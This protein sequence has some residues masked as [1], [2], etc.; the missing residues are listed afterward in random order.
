MAKENKKNVLS[1]LV[2]IFLIVALLTFIT[3]IIISVMHNN[4]FLN[5]LP[6]LLGIV[7]I[8]LFII[9]FIVVGIKNKN[10]KGSL[11]VIIGSI[12]I[13]LYSVFNILNILG[14]I[15]FPNDEYV[16]NFY[17]ISI[18]EVNKW[19]EKNNIDIE[20][21]YEYSDTI[22]IYNIIT[23]DINYPTFVKDI[24][25]ICI[26]ISLGPDYNKEI[27]VPNFTGL[28][29]DEVLDYIEKN[30]LNNVEIDYILS[31]NLADTVIEQDKSG[32]MKRND[33]IKIVFSKGTEELENIDIIDLTDKKELEAIAWLK[34]YGYDYKI[35]EDYSEKIERGHVIKQ[36]LLEENN[37]VQLTIS[38]GK[39]IIS[40]NLG[41]MSVDE[42]NKWI[43][44]NNLKI[45]YKE[46]YSDNIRLGDVIDSSIK[47]NDI[48][49]IGD[50]IEITISKGQLEMIKYG[51]INEFTNW[52][53]NNNIDYEIVYENS[54]TVK[55]DEIISSS[56]KEGQIIKDD[57]TIIIKVS[58]GKSIKVP[59]FI[60][61]S[62]SDIE[63]KCKNLNLSCSFKYGGYTEK[64]KKDI[65]TNQ[66]KKEG[67]VVSEGVN[68]VITLSNGIYEKVNVPSFN[69]KSKSE[70]EKQCKSIGITC[71]FN[72]QSSYS[73]TAKDI[74]VSQSKTGTVNKGSTIS[75]TLSKGPAT[76]YTVIIDANQLS[77]GNPSQT[78]STLESKL[79]SAC[80]GVTFKFT[81]QKANSGIGY[82]AQNSEVKI[83]SNKL[84]QGKTYN[85]IINSN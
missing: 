14:I 19:K 48:L 83:G 80:P 82:L 69:G 62:K 29:Y 22:P 76:T 27:I 45:S 60:N 56:H 23:Q 51:T 20:E 39:E 38:K 84:T 17:N 54:E 7:A 12:L 37:I 15:N 78:K 55:K 61:L 81:Y 6:N 47:E 53:T 71:Q 3:Y 59:N 16:P 85:V 50:T 31:N 43:R 65:A 57:D 41:D 21:L 28:K 24:N 66:S 8:F 11:S 44:E 30:Y 18:S 34:K 46:S 70:I 26:T 77:S 52:A 74:C 72:Y 32:T 33:H 49:S 64:T 1:I 42:I 36:E 68:L 13:I 40:P 9:C 58:K 79:K 73:S 67:T 5:F 75:I 25:K 35:I 2:P 4:S 10:N 63:S